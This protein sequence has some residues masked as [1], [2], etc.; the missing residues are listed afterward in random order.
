SWIKR[1]A[2]QGAALTVIVLGA[3]SYLW[4]E[5]IKNERAAAAVL[6]QAE[7]VR[8]RDQEQTTDRIAFLR[9][10]GAGASRYAREV[11]G[12]VSL[13][14]LDKGEDALGRLEQLLK[15]ADRNG[16]IS[17]DHGMDRQ[18]TPTASDGAAGV[19][20]PL[21]LVVPLTTFGD[22]KSESFAVA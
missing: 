15:E 4:L 3:A 9:G 20:P 18:A 8:G 17:Y 12:S 7:I 5:R 19:L 10:K 22:D 21:A 11:L 2:L 1:R 14:L 6:Q 16:S 13:Y